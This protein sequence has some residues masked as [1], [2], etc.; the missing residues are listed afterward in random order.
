MG[1]PASDPGEPGAGP[2]SP[3][4]PPGA[5]AA[6]LFLRFGTGGWSG[7]SWPWRSSSARELART[8]KNRNVPLG[9]SIQ[10]SREI[11]GAGRDAE[12]RRESPPGIIESPASS[13][14]FPEK[15]PGI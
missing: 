10:S 6:G 5:G 14:V 13:R 12:I 9:V 1:A 3:E 8:R 4:F 2:G 15:F 7:I 11:P